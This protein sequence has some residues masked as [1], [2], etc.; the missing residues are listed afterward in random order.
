M[1]NAFKL[2]FIIMVG[3]LTSCSWWEPYQEVEGGPAL[4]HR[5]PV[6]TAL[7]RSDGTPIAAGPPATLTSPD[8]EGSIGGHLNGSM[9][10]MDRMKLTHALDNSPGKSTHWENPTTGTSYTVVPT[11]KITINQNP[12]CRTYQ[13]TAVKE[14]K[15]R[16]Y[17]GAACVNANGTWQPV[18]G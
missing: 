8:G 14:G 10:S 5:G 15:E 16:Q 18:G 4:I 17:T 7:Y 9:D 2:F 12:Y 3:N 6:N 11:K 1:N 13:V